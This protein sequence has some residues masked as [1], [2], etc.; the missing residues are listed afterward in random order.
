MIAVALGLAALAVLL[1]AARGFARAPVGNAK[2]F[3]AW[4][5]VLGGLT[6]A[7]LLLLTGRVLGAVAALAFA[8]PL[9]WSW[10]QEGRRPR[11]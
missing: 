3:L 10:R 4:L 6:A 9:A 1:G 2:T 7:V 5:T 11:R 8:V